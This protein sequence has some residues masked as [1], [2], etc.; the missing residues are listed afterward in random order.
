MT[1]RS[2][3]LDTRRKRGKRDGPA[4]SVPSDGEDSIE[5]GESE[6]PDDVDVDGVGNGISYE[7]SAHESYLH[8]REPR[9]AYFGYSS[10][11]SLSH[12]ES[13]LFYQ[14]HQL[15]NDPPNSITRS[16]TFSSAAAGDNALSRTASDTSKQSSRAYHRRDQSWRNSQDVDEPLIMYP[17]D[18]EK[19][20]N[21][22][23]AS[24][25]PGVAAQN[26]FSGDFAATDSQESPE[27]A[28]I[29]PELTQI[30]QRIKRM[31][32]LRHKYINTSLQ[33][34]G[35]NPKD[36]PDH[37]KIYPPPPIPTWDEN[38]NRSYGNFL[39]LDD[40]GGNDA[41]QT[42][43]NP[44]SPTLKRRKPGQ[45]IGQD[46]N[47][48]DL[49]PLPGPDLTTSF[50]LDS[51]SVFQIHSGP[52]DNGVSTPLVRVP[53]LRDYYKDMNTVQDISSDGPTKSFAYRELDILEG[54]FHL[55]SLVNA[56]QETADCKR[57][58]R[59]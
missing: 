26:V 41:V 47:M 19:I 49:E 2:P 4:F 20:P 51:W 43:K 6:R 14:R 52:S 16:R 1:A 24:I 35:E 50:K 9:S 12:T 10:E 45:D 18:S 8:N 36:K 21:E 44:G 57:V 42:N 40:V 15:Y 30:A 53:T 34:H 7:G 3:G 17:Q 54:K 46:F 48:Q 37:W 38:K 56:Y 22:A 29:S 33:G 59:K 13:K 11:K 58:P 55:Y 31:L 5:W 32:E 39:S 28:V 27:E 23:F 25:G